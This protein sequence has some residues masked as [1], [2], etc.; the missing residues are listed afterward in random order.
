M[1]HIICFNR[2][3]NVFNRLKAIMEMERNDI[4]LFDTSECETKSF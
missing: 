2:L 3:Y 4:E 1:Q